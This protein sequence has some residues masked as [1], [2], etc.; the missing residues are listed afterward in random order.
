MKSKLFFA[1]ELFVFLFIML[2]FLDNNLLAAGPFG[3]NI[4]TINSTRAPADDPTTIS[5]QAGNVTEMNIFGFTVTQTWQG[6]FGNVTGTLIL[7][8]SGNHSMYNWTTLNPKGEIYAS[9]NSSIIWNYVMCLN[10]SATGTYSDDSA[11]IGNTSLYG[12]N[13][14]QLESIFNINESDVD[15]V[16]ETFNLLGEN[17][18]ESLYTGNLNFGTGECRSSRIF[19]DAGIGEDNKFEEVLLYESS[20]KSII[21][22]SLLNSDVLGF[23]ERTH[24]FEMMVLEDGHGENSEITPYYFYLEIQ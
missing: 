13:L 22:T 4:T 15:G 24:D 10:Y 2:I 6:Y 12:T 19:S 17:T 21:F 8:D 9:T 7:G 3:A 16:N 14:T 20:T 5:A 11:N 23:D 18:H 1:C